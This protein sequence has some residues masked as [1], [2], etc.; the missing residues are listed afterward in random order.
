MRGSGGARGSGTGR[1]L[2]LQARRCIFDGGTQIIRYPS[3]LVGNGLMVCRFV[4]GGQSMCYSSV[5]RS[6]RLVH[7]VSVPC[8]TN[9]STRHWHVLRYKLHQLNDTPV[10][11]YFGMREATRRTHHRSCSLLAT[12]LTSDTQLFTKAGSVGE[13]G[14]SRGHL[15]ARAAQALV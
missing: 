5:K 6:S 3:T 8:V 10:A 2:H 9:A 12:T 15:G 1:P 11:C 7:L 4:L 13:G 14:I